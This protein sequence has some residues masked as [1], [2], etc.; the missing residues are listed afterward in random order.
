MKNIVIIGAGYGGILTAK[1]L[2]KL[3]K[4]E[5]DVKITLIDKNPFST[6]LTELHEVAAGRVEE[7]SIKIPLA[8]V[9]AGRRVNV[10][11][12]EISTVNFEEKTVSGRTNS[13]P[14]DFLVMAAGSKP[15]YYGVSGA[16][17]NAL[18]LW[19]YDD[20]VIVREHIHA[21]FRRAAVS[22]DM[23]ERARLLTFFVVGAGFTGVEMVGELAE[24]LPILCKR[25][26]IKR[27]E[28]RIFAADVLERVVP[29]LPEKLS[30]KVERRL[31]KMGVELLLKTGVI[32]VGKDNIEV[33]TDG[34]FTTHSTSTVIWTAGIES[35][36]ITALT[37]KT[38]P[39]GGR[40]RLATDSRLCS[41]GDESVYI[42]GDNLFYSP[43]GG[44]VVPQ[45]VENCEQSADIC[46]HNIAA[47]ITGKK[48]PR[49]YSPKMHGVMVSV[50]GRYGAARVGLP[51]NMI[52]LPSF[53]AMFT[54]HFINVIY[55]VQVLGWN[56]VFS[57]LRHE[58]FTVRNSRSFLGGHFS[59]RTP[60]FLLF[61]LRIWLGAV[62]LFEGIMKA[63]E[64][65]MTTPKL[66]AFFGGANSWYD[67]ILYNAAV[68][69]DAVS[70]ATSAVGET[71]AKGVAIFNQSILGL[72]NIV[73]VSGKPL[74][75]A[76][77]A[78]YAFKLDVPLMNWLVDRVILPSANVQIFMQITIVVAEILIGLAIMAGLFTTLSTGASLVL[79]VMFVATTGLYLSTFWMIFAAIALLIGGGRTLGADYYVM[80][81]LKQRWQRVK[82]AKKWYV[83]HD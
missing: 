63:V 4:K 34:R 59:N 62:W 74:A 32:R 58:F 73:F 81:F 12:D 24:Y 68:V 71:A 61:P 18:S 10:V 11:Q 28:V 39:S 13:Y 79:Q 5:Q 44:K 38:L 17:E 37:A 50:G 70:E 77:I 40:G 14:Y 56:K 51:D 1:K 7:D 30:V 26:D 53:L 78:D 27:T 64:G 75:E 9:F 48:S 25:F 57:Y 80:P 72:F 42:V 82:F 3:L 67:N 60:S 49:P 43:P 65:W 45:M 19:S 20:A 83:Y 15:T 54:K 36:D 8:K 55:F 2:A 52:N 66:A 69:T 47:T 23:E 6:M 31:K 33:E 21:C 41:R 35:A 22:T 16:K 29:I 46:A 76:T